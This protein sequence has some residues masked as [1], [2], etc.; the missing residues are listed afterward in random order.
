LPEVHR[1]DSVPPT[2]VMAGVPA[3]PGDLPTGGA[4][5]PGVHRLGSVPSTEVMAGV[6]A[7]P[8]DLPTKIIVRK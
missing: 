3:T 8:G 7:T 6:S 4:I 2:E 1:R 5:L